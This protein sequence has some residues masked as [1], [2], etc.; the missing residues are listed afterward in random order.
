MAV[1]D[2][3]Q[4]HPTSDPE[5]KLTSRILPDGDRLHLVVAREDA[6][7]QIVTETLERSGKDLPAPGPEHPLDRLHD[8]GPHDEVGQAIE[9]LA[10]PVW[11]YLRQPHTTHN[12]G[13]ELVLAIRVN[14]R[15]K[16]ATQQTMTPLEIL[17]LFQLDSSEFSLYLPNQTV[18]L[19]PGTGIALTRGEVFEA[20]KDGKYGA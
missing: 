5:V 2:Q 19:P 18:P 10:Q 11:E 4:Q 8:L 14:K 17:A 1:Q 9:D 16:V 3:I 15:W 7:E 12:F 13:V 20:Q 6:L